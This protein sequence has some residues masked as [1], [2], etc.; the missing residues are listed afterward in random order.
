MS[1][2]C[3]AEHDPA[4]A[5]ELFAFEALEASYRECR[6][7]KRSTAN[8]LRFEFDL[9]RNLTELVRD[10]QS[11]TYQPRRSVASALLL[12]QRGR[13]E[14]NAGG[15]GDLRSESGLSKAARPRGSWVLISLWSQFGP[16]RGKTGALTLGSPA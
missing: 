12:A 3:V 16:C 2:P 5:R 1:V 4:E 10:L 7:R 15:R 14:S 13:N 6:R 11:G 9:E 8:A